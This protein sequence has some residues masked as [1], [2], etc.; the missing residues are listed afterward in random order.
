V[1]K[2]TGGQVRNQ[3]VLPPRTSTRQKT[4][5]YEGVWNEEKFTQTWMRQAG[6]LKQGN[7]L[8]YSTLPGIKSYRICWTTY[9]NVCGVE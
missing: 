8:V 2:S 9:E 5:S 4:K 3:G 6:A 1:F 7:I